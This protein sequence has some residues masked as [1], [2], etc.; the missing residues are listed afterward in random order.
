MK[1]LVGLLCLFAIISMILGKHL[2]FD[3]DDFEISDDKARMFL[4]QNNN[5]DDSNDETDTNQLVDRREFGKN[6]VRC[7]FKVNPCCAPHICVKKF[8]WNECMEI[9]AAGK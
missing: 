8:F 5:D 9:K 3:N 2:S 7:K 4:R 6:C 1:F